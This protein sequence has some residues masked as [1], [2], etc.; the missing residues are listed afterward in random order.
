[1]TIRE[2]RRQVGL[3]MRSCPSTM[4]LPTLI[5][6]S[7]SAKMS[8]LL[9]GMRMYVKVGVEGKEHAPT[10]T[11]VLAGSVTVPP[12]GTGPPLS[13]FGGVVQGAA[14]VTCSHQ[15]VVDCHHDRPGS[16]KGQLDWPAPA[17][18]GRTG[19]APA[20]CCTLVLLANTASTLGGG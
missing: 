10:M 18:I 8:W 14:G 4:K 7:W 2:L 6:K 15:V 19:Q 3:P 17:A 13:G 16:E 12:V 5:L 1:M 20:V 11:L 9:A